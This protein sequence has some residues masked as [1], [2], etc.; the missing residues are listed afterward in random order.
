MLK[1]LE[2]HI[3]PTGQIRTIRIPAVD[4]RGAEGGQLP[5]NL[6]LCH[7]GMLER[8]FIVERLPDQ[9]G[10]ADTPAAIHRHEFGILG[11]ESILQL[12]E[13]FFSPYEHS[14]I[15][16]MVQDNYFLEDLERIWELK[17]WIPDPCN[18]HLHYLKKES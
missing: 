15:Y 6:L 3:G 8:E 1:D 2:N 16:L 18:P 14:N 17:K 13:F 11:L 10:L 7:T 5:G 4:K 9:E 12:F